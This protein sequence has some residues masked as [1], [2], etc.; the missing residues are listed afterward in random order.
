MAKATKKVVQKSTEPV[1]K[2]KVASIFDHLSFITDKKV[3][4]SELSDMD[5]KSF[6]F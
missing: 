1:E 5:K 2:V 4:W 3:P 6:S